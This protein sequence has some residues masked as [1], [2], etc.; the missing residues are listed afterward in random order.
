[1]NIC[2]FTVHRLWADVFQIPPQTPM[3]N[4]S[5]CIEN[6]TNSNSMTIKKTNSIRLVTALIGFFIPTFLL[7]SCTEGNT[8]K[9]PVAVQ[10]Y[11]GVT[12]EVD[13]SNVNSLDILLAKDG[14][15]NRKGSGTVDTLDKNF[16]MGITKDK[17]FD[18]LMSQIPKDLLTYCNVPSPSCDTMKPTCKIKIAFGNND[19]TCNIDYCVNGVL[20]DLPKSIKEF[21]DKA[22]LVTDPW[23]Q[24][25]KKLLL[26]KQKS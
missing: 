3:Q 7:C 4:V 23:Y 6:L 2:T 25:Q 14:T 10:S 5:N 21:I 8:Q 13:I 19:F 20:N 26:P 22:I 9:E 12:I 18:S 16:F 11:D 1:M 17:A 15:I 24:D